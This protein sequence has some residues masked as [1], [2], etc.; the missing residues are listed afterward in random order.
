M[1]REFKVVLFDA[2]GVLTVHKESF[3][4]LYAREKK[5]EY[6]A[7]RA[8]FQGEFQQ[9]LV[10]KADLKA[11]VQKH[12]DLWRTDGDVDGLL[13]RWFKVEDTRNEPLLQKVAELRRAGIP[14]Y[15]ATNQEKYRGSHITNSMFKDEFDGYFVSAEVGSKKPSREF[16]L[17][18]IDAIT[19]KHPSVNPADILFIDDSPEH[20]EGAVAVGINAHLYK[21]IDQV[22]GLLT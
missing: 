16:F 15:L 22:E 4:A 1:N 12:E 18:V 19:A 17:A 7:F 20:V 11:L 21:S 5:I 6:S 8:F 3:S 10:G 2:D 13:D 14:C 9:A